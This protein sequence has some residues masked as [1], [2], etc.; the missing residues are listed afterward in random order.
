MPEF[1]NEA[2]AL[3][4]RLDWRGAATRWKAAKHRGIPGADEGLE[5]CRRAEAVIEELC[6]IAGEDIADRNL[7]EAIEP[8]EAAM[9]VGGGDH[10]RI[11]PLKKKWF[12]LRRE[13]MRGNKRAGCVV[14]AISIPFALTAILLL[15][16]A[17]L[18]QPLPVVGGG[19]AAMLVFLALYALVPALRDRAKFHLIRLRTPGRQQLKAPAKREPKPRQELKGNRLYVS[20]KEKK[21]PRPT[22][23]RAL[24]EWRKKAAREQSDWWN[25]L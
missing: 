25:N 21:A 23:S 1:A 15:E 7:R 16:R 17:N 19:V 24:E 18:P 11:L 5:R 6:A 3:E 10:P 12:Q 4:A 20:N 14:S 9:E 8:L 13:L 2:M 22:R